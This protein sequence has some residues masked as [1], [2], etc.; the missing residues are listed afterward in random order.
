MCER[1]IPLALFSYG[2]WFYGR[3]VTHG[4]KNVELRVAQHAVAADSAF[5][6][7]M[8]R[9][10]VAAKCRNSRTL[11][12]RN[13]PSPSDEVLR[14][15]EL[16]AR[17]ALKAE[18]LPEL[19]GLEGSAARTYFGELGGAFKGEGAR[20]G[21]FDLDGRNRRPPRDPVNA[22]MSFMYA[23]LAKD[24]QLAVVNVGLDPLLGFYH[25][26][27][28]GRPALALDL[29]E[30]FRSLVGDSIVLSVIGTGVL[31]AGDF[32]LREG[33]ATLKPNARKKML[34]AYERRMDQQVTH[35]V[36]GY[37]AQYR[38][39]IEI[40]CRLLGRHLLGEIDRYPNFT[41]R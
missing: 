30:E 16:Y 1:E 36:F 22:M 25:Q 31:D 41:T 8:A 29:M 24:C 39:I 6:L 14:S 18:S 27:R 26:P 5:C 7:R 4:T 19:L 40:Q 10:M 28:F 23:L 12:R 35:P 34:M 37:A 38:Q 3:L 9:T 11:L 17:K 2:G 20:L 15:L 33:S 21:V 13:H 32:L